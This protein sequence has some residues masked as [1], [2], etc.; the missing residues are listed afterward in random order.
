VRSQNRGAGG[1]SLLHR[2]G[3]PV[4][5]RDEAAQPDGDG[6]SSKIR[7]RV[8]VREL[9][10]RHEQEP[11]GRERTSTL[12]LDLRKIGADVRRI[13]A[14]T[15]VPK[16]PRIV[17]PQHVVGDTEDIEA[18][19]SVEVDHRAKRKLAVAPT[20]VGVKLAE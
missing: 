8:V 10:A 7:V 9:E 20:R 6:V 15:P 2:R 16:R 3:R 5:H 4:V 11:I 19:R 1:A 17:P 18:R 14:R 12:A 13:Q